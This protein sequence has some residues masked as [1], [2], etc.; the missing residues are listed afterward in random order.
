MAEVKAIE[1][2]LNQVITQLE[3]SAKSTKVDGDMFETV[4]SYC[5]VSPT[6]F[7]VMPNWLLCR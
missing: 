5:D 2:G 4:R 1:R 6:F 3:M 7:N